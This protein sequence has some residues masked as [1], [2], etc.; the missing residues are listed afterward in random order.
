MA[1]LS[2]FNLI[3][4]LSVS[5]WHVKE[6]SLG[7]IGMASPTPRPASAFHSTRVHL[8]FAII[9]STTQRSS[10]RQSAPSQ[11]HSSLILG[12]PCASKPPTLG[13]DSAAYRRPASPVARPTLS[14]PYPIV[15][16]TITLSVAVRSAHRQDDGRGMAIPAVGAAERGQPLPT[17]FLHHH[18]Q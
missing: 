6:G 18:V 9:S 7:R 16:D 10:T 17:S 1:N 12:Q 5:C 4:V 13:S 2:V 15:H 14:T 3:E 8:R 11:K